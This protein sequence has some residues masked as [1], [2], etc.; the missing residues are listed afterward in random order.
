MTFSYV[1]WCRFVADNAWNVAGLG[2]GVTS[3]VIA[4]LAVGPYVSQLTKLVVS[5]FIRGHGELA[6]VHLPVIRLRT[7]AS[8]ACS[9]R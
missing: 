9:D 2:L 3:V 1:S 6:T 5:L 7:T 4:S 8:P